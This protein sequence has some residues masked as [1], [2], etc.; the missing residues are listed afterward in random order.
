MPQYAFRFAIFIYYEYYIYLYDS[1]SLHYTSRFCIIHVIYFVFE[2]EHEYLNWLLFFVSLLLLLTVLMNL[3]AKNLWTEEKKTHI[4]SPQHEQMISG[5]CLIV[6]FE[7]QALLTIDMSDGLALYGILF[8]LTPNIFCFLYLF[9][10]FLLYM[11]SIKK[12]HFA[13]NNGTFS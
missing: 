12:V 4:Y 2:F 6:P 9:F 11:P 13:C 3:V 5:V 7:K 8:I 10:S 1:L